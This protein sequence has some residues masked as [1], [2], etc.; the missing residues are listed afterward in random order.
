ELDYCYNA[1]FIEEDYE[2][3]QISLDI[4]LKDCSRSNIIE[5]WEVKYIQSTTSYL[6]FILLL[7][8]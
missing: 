5:I 3:R 6:Q 4:V 1:G 2:K 7:N 8:N